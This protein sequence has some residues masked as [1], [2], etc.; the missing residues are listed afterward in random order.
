MEHSRIE[1]QHQTL[2]NQAVRGVGFQEQGVAG[3][4][5]ALWA[6]RDF[7]NQRYPSRSLQGKPPLV[8]FPDAAHSQREYRPEWEAEM[9]DMAR[10]YAYLAKGKWYRRTTA[11]GIFSLGGQAITPHGL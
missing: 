6:R 9:L 8:V 3:L 11:K 5:N 1:R 2:F 10:V 4:Q 7:L